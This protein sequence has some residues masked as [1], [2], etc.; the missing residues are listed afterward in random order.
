MSTKMS[1]VPVVQA[2]R[3]RRLAV[4]KRS[5]EVPVPSGPPGT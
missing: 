1:Y 3:A 5:R 2:F 4:L